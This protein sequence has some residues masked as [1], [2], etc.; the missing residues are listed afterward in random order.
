MEKAV[1][2]GSERPAKPVG[3]ESAQ[4]PLA[5]PGLQMAAKL[6]RGADSLLTASLSIL[7]AL[8]LAF[9]CYALW[10][11]W[12]IYDDAGIDEALLQYKPQLDGEESAG[13]AELRAINPD[14]CAWLTLD[15]TNIDYPIL[16]GTDNV[17]YVNTD[18]Y[19]TF[20]LSGSIFLDYR[21]AA[22]FTDAYSL[23]YGHHMEGGHMFG[24][25]ASFAEPVYFSEHQNGILYLPDRNCRVEIFACLQTDAYDARIFTPGDLSQAEMENFLDEIAETAVQYREIGVTAQDRILALSTC[26]D[27]STNARTVVLARLEEISPT[28]GAA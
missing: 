5:G 18:V 19:G 27:T 20:S 28:E 22:D 2:R 26:S 7:L 9:A 15:D 6:A 11:T 16:Q 10:D 21:N 17:K 12:R 14:V 8:I 23:V 1:F 3:M 4:E 24:E 13:F 25:L